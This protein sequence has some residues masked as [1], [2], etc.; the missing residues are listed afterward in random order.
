MLKKKLMMAQFIKLKMDYLP[1]KK[2]EIP[3]APGK[4]AETT[5]TFGYRR[6]R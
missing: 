3:E 6:L 4:P 2:K 5:G 1:E